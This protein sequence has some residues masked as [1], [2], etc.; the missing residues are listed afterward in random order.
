L[1]RGIVSSSPVC[2]KRFEPNIGAQAYWQGWFDGAAL[3]NPG[4]LGIGIVL[5]SPAGIRSETS[6]PVGGSGCNNEAELHALC[7]ALELAFD[8]GAR[9]LLLQ[10]DS[11]VAIRYALGTDSTRIAR[12]V[13]LID[14]ARES[15]RRF[16]EVR[17]VWVPRHRNLEADGL[18]RQALDLP[19]T[20]PKAATRRRRSR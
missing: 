13:V 20:R 12:L 15:M 8:A 16:E 1:R 18:S 6:A 14:R 7:T 4:K 9:H 19:A 3:P 17:L 11:D 10:G 5:V 2:S